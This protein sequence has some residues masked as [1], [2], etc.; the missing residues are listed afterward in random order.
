MCVGVRDVCVRERDVWQRYIERFVCMREKERVCVCERV[1][2][3]YVRE[4]MWR[5]RERD[6]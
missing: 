6:V 1:M 5:E 4:K 2:C 3:V